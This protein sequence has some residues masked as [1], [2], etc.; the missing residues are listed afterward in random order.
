MTRQVPGSN[1]PAPSGLLLEK[2]G[3]L[4]G[5]FSAVNSPP[6]KGEWREAARGFRSKPRFRVE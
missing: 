1:H 5:R 2:E 4:V 3:G 6:V